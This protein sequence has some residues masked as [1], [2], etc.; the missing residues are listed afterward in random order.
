MGRGALRAILFPRDLGKP[1]VDAMILGCD[2][3]HCF[4]RGLRP[5]A[6]A[7]EIPQHDSLLPVGSR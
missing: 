1:Q 3:G 2:H 7:L 5:Q 6:T 4:A